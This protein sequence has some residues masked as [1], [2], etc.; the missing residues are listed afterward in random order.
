MEKVTPMM[1]QYHRIKEIHKDA[2]LMF[3]LGDFYEMFF[4]DAQNASKILQ[5]ALTARHGTPMC[6]I[7]YHA[8][9]NY[10]SKLTRAGKKVA[11]CD[12]VT[13]PTGKGIVEREVMRIV[14]PGTT[15]DEN[16]IDSRTNNYVAC[17]Y[18]NK[19]I[20]G[21][22]YCDITTGD[23]HST[24]VQNLN[25]LGSE[26]LR[27]SPAEIIYDSN[28]K[29]NFVSFL[30]SLKEIYAFPFSYV[31]VSEESLKKYF[32]IHS[33]GVFGLTDR[34]SAIFASGMLYEY[35]LE[36][37]KS[38]IKHIQKISSYAVS[39]F[40][41]LDQSCIR[42]LEI[43]YTSRDKKEG[44]VISILDNTKTPMGGRMMRSFMLHPLLKKN[45]IDER[46][47]K[48]SFF[49]SDSNLLRNL[50]DL[51]NEIFDI[52]RLLS[53]LSLGTG[54]ARD[55]VALKESLKILPTIKK[56]SD[57]SNI[58]DLISDLGDFSV[59]TDL[60]DKAIVDAP[61]LTVREGGIIKDSYNEELDEL[62]NIGTEG[63]TFIRNLQER[64]ISR[65]GIS[66]LKI[67]FNSVFGYYI[68]ISKSN[69]SAVPENYIR[70]QTLVNA[71]RFITPELKEYEEKVLNAEEKIRQ[72][73]YEIFYK[74]RMEVVKNMNEIQ[75]CARAIALIDVFS[76][77]A[78]NAVKNN[79]CRPKILE[80]DDSFEITNGRH[81]VI[82]RL[83]ESSNFVPN[84]LAMSDDLRFL[85]ITGPNMGGKSTY[86]RQVAIIVLMAQI[87]SY[88]PADSAKMPIFDRIFTRVGAS[89]NLVQ[90]ES[91]FM[92]EM[93]EASHILNHATDKSLIILDEV[94]RG[95][96]TY[97][98][99]SI[100]WAITE[101]IHNF[102]KA[103]TLFATHYHELMGL[104]DSL[105]SAKNFSVAIKENER[106]GVVFL[107]KIIEGGIDRSYGI[108][109]AKLAGLPYEIVERA[110][111]V[112]V[113][114]ENKKINKPAPD[115][116]QMKL[117]E[118]N[119]R[120]HGILS[121]LR[122]LDID[123]LTP[124]QALQKLDEIKKR[125]GS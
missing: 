91:T 52:E 36:T 7:P 81:P 11:I 55:L 99:V 45:E 115:P 95:T 103:K 66:S 70:K 64:E 32:G 107:Y 79:Y 90:G 69:L 110:K 100:A 56:L 44:S 1:A 65:T 114:L 29:E 58:S 54:N 49:V 60:I 104:A 35:L 40:M 68:E 93:Q 15:F 33:L 43:F 84:D 113:D 106:D 94:G 105:T 19:G 83:N 24:E 3:R 119:E 5:I 77:F 112:L 62:R 102:V 23:F 6:G 89:D 124:L 17:A 82:E 21:F 18:E 120:T 51:L 125:S 46:L 117:F 75:A 4:E 108:E 8:L 85:L 88:V 31:K 98:G 87:G 121:E 76:T 39:D 10:L 16:I 13:E 80:D 34:T 92:V 122:T 48:V 101:Y 71:E 96:S 59:L 57:F 2:I 20:F 47:N 118:A 28:S 27:V 61:S 63:K 9:D 50:R 72:L 74:V 53:R 97:D 38:D 67:K 78:F 109:V 14:T 30:K 42:N 22:A 123:S 12:Q 41:I 26:I 111:E 116:S 73:E 37:Q 86:L 25:E